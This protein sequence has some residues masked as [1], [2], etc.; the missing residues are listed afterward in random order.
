MSGQALTSADVSLPNSA[1]GW[2]GKVVM[3]GDFAHRRLPKSFIACCDRWLSQGISASRAQLGEHWLDTYLS[4]PVWRFAWAPGV[5]DERWWFGVV[6]PSVDAV[7]RYFPLVVAASDH[8]P[9][10]STHALHGLADWYGHASETALSTLQPTA[11]I[12]GFEARLMCLPPWQAGA[13]S[14]FENT[15]GRQQLVMQGS[16]DLVD[17]ARQL[18]GPSVAKVYAGHSFWMTGESEREDTKTARLTVVPGLPDSEQFSM[19]LEG[20]W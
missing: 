7:G 15:A 19:M 3:L 13:T 20:R 12:D 2:F 16:P 9:P 6:M 4:S 17:W 8:N 1:P 5:V 10:M 14:R 11:S 18:A